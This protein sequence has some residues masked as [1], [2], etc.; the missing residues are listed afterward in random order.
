[1]DA[2]GFLVFEMVK[3]ESSSIDVSREIEIG[4]RFYTC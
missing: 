2:F 1:L 4:G 3:M